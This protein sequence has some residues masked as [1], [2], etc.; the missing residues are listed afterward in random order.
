MEAYLRKIANDDQVGAA[1]AMM[2]RQ[3]KTYYDSLIEQGF[4]GSAALTLTL[5]YQGAM[6]GAAFG[7]E[8]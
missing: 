8:K 6:L 2:A 7:R 1:V 3:L 4:D 5:A